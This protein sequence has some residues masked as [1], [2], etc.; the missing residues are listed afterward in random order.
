VGNCAGCNKGLDEV[1]GEVGVQFIV[2]LH[3]FDRTQGPVLGGKVGICHL[4]CRLD[5]AAWALLGEINV[6]KNCA[7]S[8]V[9]LATVPGE[10]C[11]QFFVIWSRFDRTQG[12]VLGGKVGYRN[13][14]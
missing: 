6:T 5:P 11:I 4:R 2:L 7:G 9:G 3:R 1:S 10:I 12:P 13:L 14:K 8:N